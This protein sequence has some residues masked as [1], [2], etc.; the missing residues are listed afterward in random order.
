MGGRGL[1]GPEP[2]ETLEELAGLLGGAVGA[3]RAATDAGWVDHSYQIGL[4]G[5]TVTPKLYITVGVSGASQHMGGM[6]GR[7]THRCSKS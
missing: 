7:Q 6:L 3:S 1:G 4:T 2:F 5:K